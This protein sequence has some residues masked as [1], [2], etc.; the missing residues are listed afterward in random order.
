MTKAFLGTRT[1]GN[2]CACWVEAVGIEE[3]AVHLISMILKRFRGRVSMGTPPKNKGR[4]RRRT[5]L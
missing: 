5:F 2:R 3:V 1:L 4:T